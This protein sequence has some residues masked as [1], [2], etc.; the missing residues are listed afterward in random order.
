M[1]FYDAHIHFLFKCPRRDV[2]RILS[3]LA[4]MGML[5]FDVF[6]IAEYPRDIETVLRM[7]PKGYHGDIT[8]E[9]LDNQKDPFPLLEESGQMSIIPFLD[10]R[11]I[12][13]NIEKKIHKYRCM[14]FEGLKLLYIPEEDDL[15]KTSGM[16]QAFGRSPKQSESVTALMIESAASLGMCVTI[17]IDLRRY[18]EFM[19]DMIKSHPQTNFNIAHFGF[20]RLSIAPL[21]VKYDNC[22]TDFSALT[23]FIR[24]A[25][26]FYKE[27]I[28]RYQDRILFGS[29]A[30]IGRPEETKNTFDFFLGYLDRPGVLTKILKK[31]YLKFHKIER[32][33]GGKTKNI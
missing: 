27:F 18:G 32:K 2:K 13:N 15:L 22:Y 19:E 4:G 6:V 26:G 11:F 7:V 14:G 10:A 28:E 17:H 21:L 9:V 3:Y 5:G 29:D 30:L 12:D 8:L 24:K 31:N 1:E 20:S 33:L 16:E 25:P 23:P